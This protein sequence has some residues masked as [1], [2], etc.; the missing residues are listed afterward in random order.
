MPCFDT[1]L[2]Q[3][4]ILL[5]PYRIAQDY[6]SAPS[7]ANYV[8]PNG[9]CMAVREHMDKFSMQQRSSIAFSFGVMA[10]VAKLRQPQVLAQLSES[11]RNDLGDLK[12]YEVINIMWGC[13]RNG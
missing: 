2:R 11:V 10:S 6:D 5:P 4:V 8:I 3:L 12:L 7:M 1:A 9:P 13:V